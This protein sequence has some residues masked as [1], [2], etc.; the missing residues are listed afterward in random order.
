VKRTPEAARRSRCGV[1]KKVLPVQPRSFALLSP[2]AHCKREKDEENGKSRLARS[3]M[4]RPDLAEGFHGESPGCSAAFGGSF[5]SG[6]KCASHSPADG[7]EEKTAGQGE[8]FDCAARRVNESGRA[9]A[10]FQD[11]IL[12]H[13]EPFV[14]K[15]YNRS[16]D[17]VVRNRSRNHCGT[18][19]TGTGV[20]W[21]R[22]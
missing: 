15:H 8:G 17:K 16:E 2:R 1:R 9:G 14:G 6:L 12:L 5:T 20:H 18:R 7:C 11:F 13:Q 3:P 21:E 22:R 10:A 4:T 19:T